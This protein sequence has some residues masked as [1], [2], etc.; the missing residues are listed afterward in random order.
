NQRLIQKIF[1]I[2]HTIKS[3]AASV[4]FFN[5]ST[6]AHKAEDILH[7]LRAGEIVISGE[8]ISLL[9]SV[10]DRFQDLA[11]E[12]AI[13]SEDIEQLIKDLENYS[14]ETTTP[15]NTAVTTDKAPAISEFITHLSEYERS[16][17]DDH[18]KGHKYHY[19][20]TVTVFNDEELKGLR[21]ELVFTT[22]EKE[23]ILVKTFPERD[24]ISTSSGTHNFYALLLSNLSDSE[25]ESI[26]SIDGIEKVEFEELNFNKGA[27]QLKDEGGE[28]HSEGTQNY[29]NNLV[30]NSSEA[31]NSNIIQTSNTIRVSIDKLDKLFNLVGELIIAS[32]GFNELEMNL[33]AKSEYKQIREDFSFVS[34][35][36]MD[37]SSK[38][39]YNIMRT[40]MLPISILFN[41]FPRVVRDLSQEHGK[42]IELE[43]IGTETELDKKVIDEI[44]D[45]LK[46]ILRNAIDHGIESPEQRLKNGKE[47]TGNITIEAIQ[48]GNHIVIS[49][50][51]DGS[52]IDLE[53][54]R[55]KAVGMGYFPKT[56]P[57]KIT[58]KELLKI[59]FEP[60]FSTSSKIT[61]ISGRGVGLD[62]VRSVV[63]TLGGSVTIH[64]QPS[65]GCEFK[66]VLPLTVA[67]TTVIF[68]RAG[69]YTCGIPVGYVDQI[70]KFDV[71]KLRTFQGNWLAELNGKPVPLTF[72]ESILD[73]HSHKQISEKEIKVVVAKFNNERLGFIVDDVIGDQE[74]VVKPLEKNFRAIKGLSGAAILG[75]GKI[76]FILDIL[77]IFNLHKNTLNL[78]ANE[79]KKQLETEMTLEDEAMDENSSITEENAHSDEKKALTTFTTDDIS[80]INRCL[81]KFYSEASDSL[82]GLL[83]RKV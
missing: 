24:G 77:E 12:T 35:K 68:V 63:A 34:N 25:L 74:I 46:H 44:G 40:R 55:K 49:I 10:V 56:S 62:A 8:I 30:T 69:D 47:R 82:S 28:K 60:G 33:R 66:I 4:G 31:E 64:N 18:A 17:V 20:L 23:C 83:N 11:G 15:A 5:L 9:L 70:V 57:E 13:S 79:Y 1:R 67:T 59:I 43:L 71:K 26:I 78:A 41:Q 58:E 75:N 27:F 6:L 51:D 39:Q 19:C 48:V 52:G 16:I 29:G 54:V 3:S 76:I 53:E 42:D 80:D 81:N 50:R 73:T 32:T 45:A 36:V 37:I 22:L 14:K 7:L 21:A 38:L 2:F 65:A 61:T 72:L